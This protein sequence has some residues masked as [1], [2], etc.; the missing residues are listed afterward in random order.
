[1]DRVP[2]VISDLHLGG[3]PPDPKRPGDRGFRIFSQA[4]AL[5]NFL[6]ALTERSVGA[7]R[8]ELVINGDFVDFLAEG[9]ADGKSWSPLRTDPDA[10]VTTFR[11]I[12]K[13]EAPVFDALAAFLARGHRLT[14]LLGNHDLELSYPAVRR[15]L[16][17]ALGVDGRQH[18]GFVYD[19]EA[20]T[21]GD[22]LIEH[23]NR[24]DC[25]NTNDNEGLQKA[26][27]FQSRRAPV[28]RRGRIAVSP[29]SEL[30][31]TLINPLKAD[32]PFINLLK[33]ENEACL[34]ILWAL[35][36][37]HRRKLYY[38]AKGAAAAAKTRK[39]R[40]KTPLEPSYGRDIAAGANRD[41]LD[42]ALARQLGEEGYHILLE[43]VGPPGPASGRDLAAGGLLDRAGSMLGLKKLMRRGAPSA[44][45]KR[46]RGLLRSLRSLQNDETFDSAKEPEGPYLDAARELASLGFR[47]ILFG[48]THLP[49]RIPLGDHPLRDD[50]VSVDPNRR[51]SR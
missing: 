39:H 48:H 6:T 33:P 51:W 12:V 27:V 50:P 5:V 16:E 1:V 41:E 36:P 13:R 31:A 42:E 23:G 15:A 37:K 21:V 19:G 34:P 35:E 22:V 43:A 11:E 17:T 44:W 9:E 40:M 8:T 7:P 46:L 3:A 49:R 10:A 20:Y 29:G 26:R 4:E 24:Y 25:Y 45:E 14:L 2:Y 47:A 32:Y 38:A 18:Y 30:V 28:P